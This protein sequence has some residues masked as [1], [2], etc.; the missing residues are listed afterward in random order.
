MRRGQNINVN[1]SLEEADSNPQDNSEGFKT[2]TKELTADVVEQARELELEV[3]PKGV[4]ELL[5]FRD[6][7]IME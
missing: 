1:G 5:Q 3:K 4:T 6:N 2:S 7:T